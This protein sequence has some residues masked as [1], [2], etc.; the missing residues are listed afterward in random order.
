MTFPA[1]DAFDADR[2]VKTRHVRV[3]RYLRAVLD[4]LAIRSPKLQTIADSTGEKAPNVSVIL[5][6][7][8]TWGY[9]LEHE[10]DKFGARQFT[11]CWSREVIRPITSEP[12]PT[13][14]AAQ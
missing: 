12:T 13:T 4:F 11:L 14:P 5:D 3:Y 2:R 10:R 8:V 7:L 6:E 9:L 1:W